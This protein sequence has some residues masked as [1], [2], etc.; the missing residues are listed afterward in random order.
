[1]TLVLGI[2]PGKH[3][4][5]ICLFDSDSTRIVSWGLYAIDDASVESCLESCRSCFQDVLG[6]DPPTSIAI[7]R[8]PPQNRNMCRISHFVQMYLAITYPGVPIRVVSPGRRLAYLRQ[9]RPDL[10]LQTY[11]RR[12]KSSIAYVA[13]WLENTAS[14]WISWFAAQPK[15]DDCAESLL[16]CLLNTASTKA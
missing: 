1:M 4:A 3:H 13:W 12:K 9:T 7:E 16:L 6:D 14:D 8:Q 11:A 2:D 5:G 10:D 15:Q